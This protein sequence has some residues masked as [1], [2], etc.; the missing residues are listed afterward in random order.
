MR[1]TPTILNWTCFFIG[2][3]IVWSVTHNWYAMLGALIA[4]L[5]FT[6]TVRAK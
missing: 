6:V 5:H 3:A 1:T 2:M 4:S